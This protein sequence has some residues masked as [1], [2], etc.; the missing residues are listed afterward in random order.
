M[1]LT[2]DYEIPGTGVVVS[3]AYHVVT[4]VKVE[5]RIADFKPPPDSSRKDKVTANFYD[6]KNEVDWKAGYIGDIA[7]TI[8]KD[9]ASR[10][11]NAK[12]IG[13]VGLDSSDNNYHTLNS[14]NNEKYKFFID[15]NSPKN[16]IE[17]AYDHLMT[18]DYYKN[19]TVN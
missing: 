10:D 13:F 16:E 15:I 9:K 2:R 17:Q 3:N 6:N 19:S 7:I 5:K 12:P 1:A 4:N 8:W 18:L 11:S 14:N